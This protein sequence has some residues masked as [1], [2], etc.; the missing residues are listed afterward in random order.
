MS[1]GK[2]SDLQ[3]EVQAGTKNFWAQA[4]RPEGRSREIAQEMLGFTPE[5]YLW[6]KLLSSGAYEGTREITRGALAICA[7]TEGDAI[8]LFLGETVLFL[9][10]SGTLYVNSEYWRGD[11]SLFTP[12]YELKAFPVL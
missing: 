9:R 1:L 7:A 11:Y 5:V 8:L 6:C 12:P 2:L 3:S 10:K 4:N